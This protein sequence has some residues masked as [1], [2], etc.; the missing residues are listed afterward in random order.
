MG[1][2]VLGRVLIGCGFLLELGM[3][4]LVWLGFYWLHLPGHEWMEFP[5]VLSCLCLFIGG[6]ACFI[7]GAATRDCL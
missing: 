6:G 3:L 7:A 2:K 5:L 1:S 4:D